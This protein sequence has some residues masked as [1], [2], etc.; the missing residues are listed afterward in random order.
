MIKVKMELKKE[1]VLDTIIKKLLY[2]AIEQVEDQKKKGT[3]T[4]AKAELDLTNKKQST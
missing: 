4:Q 2:E 1:I 3:Y